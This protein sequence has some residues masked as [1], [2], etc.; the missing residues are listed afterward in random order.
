MRRINGLFLL[1]A[2]ARE[3]T[4]GVDQLKIIDSCISQVGP[5]LTAETLAA[6]LHRLRNVEVILSGWGMPLVDEAFLDAA[7]ELKAI[8][9]GAGAASNWA[10]DA[11][12]NRNVL[13]TTASMANAIPVAEYTLAMILLSLKHGW[14]FARH[15]HQGGPLEGDLHSQIPGNYRRTVGLVSFGLIARKLVELLKPHDLTVLVYDPHLAEQKEV[16]PGV[17]LVTLDE[18]FAR[19]DAISVHTPLLRETI[20]LITGKHLGAIKQG[21][22]FINTSRGAII[23]QDELLDIARRRPDIR[24]VLDV[25]TPEPLPSDSALHDLPHVL[26]TP[27]IAGSLGRECERMGQY[28]ADELLRYVRHEPLQWLLNPAAARFSAHRPLV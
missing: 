6:N 26:I 19:S 1:D 11:L 12:W 15:R 18:I 7:P 5:P 28:M 22:V 8:F 13:V 23:R 25:T 10:T 27:H 4:Y 2:R 20:G 3:V 24:F 14:S 16:L 21:G 17:E 9:Y